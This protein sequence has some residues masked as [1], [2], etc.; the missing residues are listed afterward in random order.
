M[1][2]RFTI[3]TAVGALALGAAAQVHAQ[4]EIRIGT[5]GA[6]PPYN[7][8]DAS[9]E[10][11]GFEIDM[12]REL[13]ERMGAE[14]TFV[15]QDWD[16]IIPA[17]LNGRYDVIIAGMSITDER[18][19][20]IAFSQGYVTTPAQFVTAEG[21]DY[22]GLEGID[23]TLEALSGAVLG[24]QSGTIHQTFIEQELPDADLRTYGTQEQLNLD[25]MADR[26]DVGLADASGW[27]PFLTSE[28][29]EDYTVTGPGLTGDDFS[30]F[31]EGVGIGAR[32]D[33][34]ELLARFNAALCE[35]KADGSLRELAVEWFGFDTTLAPGPVCD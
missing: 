26:V 22:D 16:G 30:V 21:S 4:D 1:T 13:C 32:Q 5:E 12:A 6:Y 3:L 9:G 18:R 34:T 14:C 2:Y 19:E 24:V 29:G 11:V 35:M 15:A 23:E 8:T 17:L 20:Q 33:D 31:G 7:F 27:E 28:E 10:L 25:L